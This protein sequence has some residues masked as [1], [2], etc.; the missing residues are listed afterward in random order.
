[1]SASRP[2]V[3]IAGATGH[4][5]RHVA[6]A[7][8]SPFFRSKFSD[9]IFLSRKE[10]SNIAGFESTA[11]YIVRKYDEDNIVKALQ[12][13][14]VLVNTI[15][16]EG[17][18]F[19]EKLVRALPQTDVEIYFPSEFGVDHYV[20]D[21]P[22]LEWDEKKKHFALAQK[23]IP[24]IKVCRLFCGLFLE[25]SIGPWF[26]FDTKNG[27]YESVGSSQSPI[28]F[29]SL[30]DV[31]KTIA[32]LAT[33]PPDLAPSTLHVGG[34]TRSISEI[35][36][37]MGAAGAGQIEVTEIPLD[38]YKKEKT[39]TPSWDPAGHLRFLMGEDKIDHTDGG[40]G[41]DNELVNPQQLLWKWTT[42]ADLAEHAG[43]RPWKDFVW[44]PQ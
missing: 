5:G 14:Q 3:A 34:D 7:F 28:S 41:N 33:L 40:L 31:G 44:P 21:F 27:K 35:A 32:A 19:K 16:P 17:H 23:F 8:L 38:E 9:I 11:D 37:I 36:S 25:D 2:V 30:D 10:A 42:L 43:G 15:G 26:G 39:A 18:S 22:H 6:S 20:H 13:V 4:L 24:D 12:G 29:T 1:M